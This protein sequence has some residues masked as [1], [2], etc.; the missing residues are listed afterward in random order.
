MSRE[1]HYDGGDSS[2]HIFLIQLLLLAMGIRG[3][4]SPSATIIINCPL[5]SFPHPHKK[6]KWMNVGMADKNFY[7]AIQL[8]S[9]ASF[10]MEFYEITPNHLQ[11]PQHMSLHYHNFNH[12]TTVTP[13]VQWT[14]TGGFV[15]SLLPQC[16]KEDI[17]QHIFCSSGSTYERRAYNRDIMKFILTSTPATGMCS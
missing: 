9:A 12:R 1:T 3:R 17:H 8:C 5:V 2:S 15:L 7:S 13:I 10:L 16:I 4:I 14:G 11:P 6:H